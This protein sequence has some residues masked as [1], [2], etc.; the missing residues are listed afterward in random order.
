MGI[1]N[2][3]SQIFD[4]TG[5]LISCIVST[6]IIF[7]FFDARYERIYQKKIV[8]I[9]LK[10]I[11]CT[12]NLVI[13][14]LDNPMVNMSYWILIIM[15]ASIFLYSC[16]QKGRIRY[17]LI[18]VS[19]LFAYSFCEAFGGILIDLGIKILD[20]KQKSEVISFVCIISSSISAILLYY[21]LLRRLL[22]R[23]KKKK[24]SITQYIIYAIISVYVLVNLGGI[25]FLMQHNLRSSDY[26]FLLLDAILVIILN[27]YLFYLLDIFAENKS[28]KYKLLLYENQ[29]KSNYEYYAKQIDSNKKALS[30]IHDIRK[31]IRV[32]EELKQTPISVQLQGYTDSFEE[33]IQPLLIK[34]Y[35]DS[36][37]LNIILNDKVDYCKNYNIDF[38]I[39]IQHISIDFMKPIDITTIFGNILDN[40]IEASQYSEEKRIQLKIY[41]FNG[42]I[43][44]HLTNTYNQP[45][46]WRLNGKPQ[47]EK[48]KG[49]GIGIEN[50][51]NTL[52]R[53]NGNMQMT[54]VGN[55]FT[56]EIIFSK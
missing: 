13:Y 33:M 24:V 28:L 44:I 6:V 45:I 15:L 25:L 56:V 26:L 32:L 50:V 54:T 4:I 19:F 12:L 2:F 36:P 46:R 49:H 10:F 11:V 41:P 29:A 37:I 34:Q 8:Y 43:Y 22:A 9:F 27:L 21:L 5:R 47:S 23:E 35:C 53:Y 31:H 39:D 16:D 52:A 30:V 48:G 42:L 40:A 7:Q 3:N 1:E 14:F 18:N 17:Y 20:I 38:D 55:L 51:E